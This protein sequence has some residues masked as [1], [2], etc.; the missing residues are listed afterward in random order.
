MEEDLTLPISA[1]EHYSYCPRQCALI[2]VEQSYDENVLTVRGRLAHE[3]VDE[4]EPSTRGATRTV[5][6]LTLWSERLGLLGKADIV[7]FHPEGPRPVEYKVG[8]KYGQHAELQLCAQA[9]C[10]EE[11]LDVSIP[12]GDLY[13]RGSRKRQVVL[14]TEELRRLTER[15]IL[16]LHALLRQD[17]PLPA[18]SD[19]CLCPNC[20]LEDVCIPAVVRDPHRLRGL[21]GSLFVPLTL[22]DDA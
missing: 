21:Q 12:W 3:R 22:G 1:I 7:E 8:R 11:M 15:V 5:R 4:G 19:P 13:F 17:G 16:A 18:V 14:F 2:H 9:M 6:N 10:L 20:S